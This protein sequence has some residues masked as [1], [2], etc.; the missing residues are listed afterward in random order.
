MATQTHPQGAQ[1]PH[2]DAGLR[3]KRGLETQGLAP[4]GAVHWN[5]VAPV[6]I[7]DALRRG[8]GSLADMGPF[9][10]VTAPHTGR[11][12]N[13][14]FVVKERGSQGDV[15]WGKVN[16]PLSEDKFE[17]LLADVRAYL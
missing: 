2:D 1:G 5:L 12:P 3:G 4:K 13:D 9:V 8:E 15:D 10:A 11:S 6:L 14:K 16:Q 7:Q 17:A